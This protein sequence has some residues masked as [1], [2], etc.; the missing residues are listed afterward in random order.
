MELVPCFPP[1]APKTGGLRKVEVS[2]P[3]FNEPFNF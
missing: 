2:S 1:S 3:G